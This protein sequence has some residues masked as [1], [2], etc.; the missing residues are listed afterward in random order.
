MIF[1]IS[2]NIPALENMKRYPKELYGIGDISLLKRPK[3]SIV[4]TRR[5]SSYTKH[6]TY[7]LAQA[8]SKRGVCLVSGAAMGVDAIVH[9][10]A[11]FDNTIAVVANSLDIRY[12][13]VN[14][15]LIESIEKEGLML[16]QFAETFKATPW[17]FVVRNELVVA[18]GDVLIVTE[19]DEKSGSMRSVEFA[20]KMG[21]KVFVLPQKLDESRGTNKLLAD[22]LAEPIY[23]IESFSNSYGVSP[24]SENIE[25]DDFFYF[26]QKSPTLDSAIE[27]FRDRVYEA[28]L[29]GLISIEN[30]L[31][32]LV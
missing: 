18:L 13:A 16:S 30:G 26:C 31:V 23:D 19:A 22:G 20:L 28:E 32:R 3:V 24:Q 14:R 6:F 4:G 5:P 29:E 7:I 10:G 11:G 2:K 1:P 25:K 27:K 21:K 15:T 12:P 17:S 9:H 8:L